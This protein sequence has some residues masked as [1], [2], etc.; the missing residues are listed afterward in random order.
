MILLYS[1]V[2]DPGKRRR[3][4]PDDGNRSPDEIGIFTMYMVLLSLS[5]M[6]LS[7]IVAYIW[8]KYITDSEKEPFSLDQFPDV[9]PYFLVST[10]IILL[11]SYVLYKAKIMLQANSL[12]KFKK[13]IICNLLF[14]FTF[15][16]SFYFIWKE[17]ANSKLNTNGITLYSFTFY[18][19]TGMH[20]FHY[21]L[22][23]VFLIIVTI[24]AYKNV[25]SATQH[26]SFKFFEIYWHFLSLVWMVLFLLFY[27]L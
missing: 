20:L 12:V 4:E 17:I 19:L 7:G 26:S 25:Y 24:Y 6:F 27:F 16:G 22:G 3:E 21:L 10:F 5:V 14:S 1:L 2:I 15:L 13:Y 9:K 23:I 8:M 11:S 18:L